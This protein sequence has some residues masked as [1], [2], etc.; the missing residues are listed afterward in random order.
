MQEAGYSRK[1][2]YAPKRTTRGLQRSARLM[3]AQIG[4]VSTLV[5]A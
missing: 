2:F 5:L 1:F 3:A 4:L